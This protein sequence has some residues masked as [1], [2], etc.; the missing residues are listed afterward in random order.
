MWARRSRETRS[1]T[2]AAEAGLRALIAAATDVARRSQHAVV[3][4]AHVLVAIAESEELWRKSFA[5]ITRHV[6]LQRVRQ[7]LADLPATAGYRGSAPTPPLAPETEALF[8][9]TGWLRQ[10]THIGIVVNRLRAQS[11]VIDEARLDLL[12][13]AEELRAAKSVAAE[14]SCPVV[15]VAHVLWSISDRAWF[16]YALGIAG[17]DRHRIIDALDRRLAAFETGPID[18]VRPS[19]HVRSLMASCERARFA[20]GATSD[21]FLAETLR[22]PRLALM[23]VDAGVD[24]ARL[25]PLLDDGL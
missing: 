12:P 6:F 8:A 5:P 21:A 3:Q 13:L 19:E 25:Q 17:G 11:K 24:V 20:L 1:S 16:A 9:P 22:D 2:T 14:R 4:P 7:Q 18:V 10:E 23:F 15:H